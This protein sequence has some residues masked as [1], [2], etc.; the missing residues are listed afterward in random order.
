[1]ARDV[2]KGRT[3]LSK[4][5]LPGRPVFVRESILCKARPCGDSTEALL[6]VGRTGVWLPNAPLRRKVA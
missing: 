4:F 1:M 2:E 6:R 3:T 5:A